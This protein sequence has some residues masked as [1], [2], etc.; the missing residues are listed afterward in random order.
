MFSSILKAQDLKARLKIQAKEMA[1]AAMT[2]DYNLVLKYTYPKFMEDFSKEELLSELTKAMEN[3]K[4][5]G[6]IIESTEIGEPGI[7][8]KAGKELHCLVSEKI[9]LKS[10][11]GR[12][13]NNSN[14]LAISLDNGQNWYFVDCA[15]GKENILIMF[16]DFNNDL[17]IPNKSNLIKLSN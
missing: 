16:P 10:K 9:I 14:L 12:F 13:Q 17:I 6:V 15:T 8:Y 7:I 2:D 5:Q 1:N 4:S 3:V 11:Q